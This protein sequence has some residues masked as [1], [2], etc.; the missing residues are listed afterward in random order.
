MFQ[1]D[2]RCVSNLRQ[3]LEQVEYPA[4]CYLNLYTKVWDQP[5]KL[6]EGGMFGTPSDVQPHTY[7]FYPSEQCGRGALGLVFSRDAALLLLSDSWT[8]ERAA[9]PV[10]GHRFVD[11]AC[12]E[13]FKRHGW[14]ELV[15]NPSLLQ[16]AEVGSTLGHTSHDPCVSFPGE[17]WDALQLLRKPSDD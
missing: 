10:T 4:R 11:G 8:Y 15:H 16:H 3:Y 1:D 12:I 5:D 6:A 7:G 13:T 17:E 2:I 14:T 9:H